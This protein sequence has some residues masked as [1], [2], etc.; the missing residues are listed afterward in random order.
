MSNQPEEWA[1]FFNA[2]AVKY[3]E[4]P[5]TKATGEELKFI[6]EELSLPEGSKILD[7]GCGTGRH[8][9]ALAKHGYKVLGVD[10]S[11]GMLE[12]ARRLAE[13]AGVQVE[14]LQSDATQM[15][16]EQQFD[17]AICLCEGA[18]GLL[19][20]GDDPLTHELNI[21]KRIHRALYPG[22]K[23]IL[24]APNGLRKIRHATKEQVE[25]GEFD[26]GTI[27]ESFKLPIETDHGDQE[28]ALRERG[29]V[30]S[31]LRLMFTIAGFA[32]DAVYGGTAG[33]WDRAPVGLDE[34]EVMMISTRQEDG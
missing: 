28:I 5:F 20:S 34:M 14:W 25:L 18:F 13:K 2:H 8:A 7:V 12:E 22:A 17:A 24:T 10:I 27:T 21:L 19:N 16:L 6:L 4:E 1:Q 31:E 33:A 26:P 3:H 32:V 23:L 29:F 30:P 11:E 9:V 15:E